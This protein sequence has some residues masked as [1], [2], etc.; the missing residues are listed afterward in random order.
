MH[1]KDHAYEPANVSFGARSR[2]L[3]FERRRFR[4]AELS[5]SHPNLFLSAQTATMAPLTTAQVDKT[6]FEATLAS[7]LPTVSPE[8]ANEQGYELATRSSTPPP[9]ASANR[10]LR[11]D[12]DRI[13]QAE[14][15][16]TS[17]ETAVEKDPNGVV[18][19]EKADINVHGQSVGRVTVRL[20][21]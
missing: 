5:C 4:S 12:I 6:A 14:A 20:A 9:D 16:L 10:T 15:G 19:P 8:L 17:Q 21:S 2:L 1:E 7:T 13:D 18:E 11:I 3:A